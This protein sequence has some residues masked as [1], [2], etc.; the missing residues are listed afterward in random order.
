MRQLDV[1][2]LKELLSSP[3]NIVITTHHKPDGDAMGS[4]LGLYHYLTSKGHAATVV[5]PNDYP[6]FLH[7]LPGE[8]HTIDF[9]K[10]PEKARELVESADL[11]FC[12]DFNASNRVEKM[13]PLLLSSTCPKV[14][15]DHHLSPLLECEYTYSYPDACATAEL[16]FEFICSMGDKAL[17]NKE[18]AECIYTGIMTDTGSF[19]FSSMKADTHRIVA[20]LISAGA[21]NYKIHEAVFDNNSE[22]RLRLLGYCITE[23]L[24][25]IPEFSTAY[26][27]VSREELNRFNHQTGDTEGIVNYALG[28]KGVRM[29]A[30]FA[31]RRDEIRISFRSRDDFSVKELAEKHFSG[32]GHKNAAGGRSS[33]SLAETARK[34]EKLLPEY[35]EQL[36]SR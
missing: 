33:L 21:E 34:F 7:W 22:N 8:N 14:L 1:R 17:L 11:L 32:G 3:K 5:V 13:E 29:A 24:R 19:R 26:I 20:D 27:T 18:I 10:A 2:G 15:I 9:E 31:E 16:V 28:I 36:T 6:E 25:V 23:K 35:K 30:F 12:L 4:S